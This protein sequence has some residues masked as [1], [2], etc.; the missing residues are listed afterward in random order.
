MTAFKFGNFDY[1]CEHAAL[2]ICPLLGTELVIS[3][4]CYSRNVQ[5][6]S[7]IIFQPGTFRS[8][9]R[10]S[11]ITDLFSAT[12]FVH[13][14]ALGMTAI[15]LFH[16]RSKYTAVGRKEIVLFFYMYMFVELLAIFLDSAIIPTSHVVYP[17]CHI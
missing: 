3:P 13:I 7:Q 14:A 4:T 5:L 10:C 8:P 17:V 15:M 9:V 12:C 11:A 1:I 16:V 6:G 2:T